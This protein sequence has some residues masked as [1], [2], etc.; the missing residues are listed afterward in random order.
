MS[1]EF[2]S[3]FER[4]RF[5]SFPCPIAEQDIVQFFS[6]SDQDRELV[7]RRRGSANRLGFAVQLCAL[8]FLGFVPSNL[9][10]LHRPALRFVARELGI[11]AKDL[12]YYA[13][14]A[15]TRS[16]H[17][18][19]IFAYL[20]FRPFK[21]SDEDTLLIWLV[22]R[23]L[24]HDR[25]TVLL[26]QSIGWLRT[27]KIVRPDGLSTLEKIVSQARIE[28]EEKTYAFISP[29][30]S[31]KVIGFLERILSI[32]PAQE[33]S[34][35][36]WLSSQ[37]SSNA[38]NSILANIE[39]LDFLKKNGVHKWDVSKLSPNRRKMLAQIGHKSTAQ[40]LRR[41][42]L[43]KRYPIIICFLFECIENVTDELLE[44]FD[45]NLAGI[46]SK[47]KNDLQDFRTATARST[48]EKLKVLSKLGGLV[49]NYGI[50]DAT[51]RKTI[52][53]HIEKKTLQA[54][55]L[56][57]ERVCR[58]DDN[59]V[60]DFF[61]SRYSYIRQFSPNFMSVLR[62]ET[63]DDFLGLMK[64]LYNL[65]MV[66]AK[67][68]PALPKNTP[69]D[70]IAKTWEPFVF[71]D[72]GEIQHRF[73]EL[74]VLWELRS[75]LRSGEVWSPHSKR[76]S[77]PDSW[78]IPL[79]LWDGVRSEYLPLIRFPSTWLEKRSTCA[80]EYKA[81]ISALNGELKTESNIRIEN[82]RLVIT[83]FSSRNDAE[84]VTRLQAEITNRLPRVELT[85]LLIEVDSWLE[86]SEC[87]TH[88]A[89]EAHR[90]GD[91]HKRL[92][93]ALFVGACNLEHDRL[94]FQASLSSEQLR[95]FTTW[96]VREETLR[97]AINRAVDNQFQNPFSK[98]FG[99]G[100][101]SSSDGQRF[102]VP[103]K[104]R[105]A[106]A[107]PKYFAHGR[108]LTFLSW[109]SDQFS[110]YGIKVAPTTDRESTYVFD[111]ISDNE[112]DLPI[113]SHTTDTAGYTD[114]VFALGD[115]LGIDFCPRIRDSASVRL[116][117][118]DGIKTEELGKAADIFT[119]SSRIREKLIEQNWDEILR[120]GGSIKMGYVSSSL[121]MSRLQAFPRKSALVQAL[122]EYGRL[123]KT[124]FILRYFGSQ[125]Y[126]R[127]IGKQLNKGESLHDLRSFIAFGKE[128]Q[129][130]KSQLET[131]T[132]Q[133]GCLTLV[134]NLVVL[135]NTRY[136][137]KVVQTLREEGWLISGEDISQISPCRFEHI[138]R[139]GRFSFD[140]E[141]APR[142]GQL[143]PLRSPEK[144]S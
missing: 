6:L 1:L 57:C 97:A 136:I 109:T 14:R 32:M 108:G 70:F 73:Y 46:H 103:V 87:F 100:S 24:E 102:P 48:D 96:F 125:D 9:S 131:Q 110:Q 43:K 19:E 141:N 132:M 101:M 27:K 37:E 30:L 91:F 113:A 143:R 53:T 124:I 12:G 42:S 64:A 11:E 128:G 71:N 44:M 56:D 4:E 111:G 52:F 123:R 63:N 83:P 58:P 39:R 122:N 23:A 114:L 75:R 82:N 26:E 78:L 38:P 80:Q 59:S 138:N 107:L 40:A 68:W 21:K 99:T 69:I 25:A 45:K 34:Y 55:V 18:S 3:Q 104:S 106:V 117:R 77:N 144:I 142:K 85:D 36:Q 89:G 95:W 112:S 135:W 98:H 15:Q 115:L 51:L 29:L 31:K 66:D 88:A 17:L 35:L 84:S 76:Y 33:H 41:L 13:T 49:L 134:A 120:I 121:L 137:E 54:M 93:V 86:F 81:A 74:C 119:K 47:A 92:Y 129:I 90:L 79:E 61:A 133:A 8:R 20:E 118:L 130:R 5:N 28:A 2:L 67:N 140:F 16:D 7:S 10:E 22:D 139:Y 126:R 72:A 50:T 94:A 127:H 116:F 60:W 105:N 62:F 65:R